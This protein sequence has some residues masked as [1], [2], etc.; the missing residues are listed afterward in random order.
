MTVYALYS[1]I[2]K[3]GKGVLAKE[4]QD[5]SCPAEIIS[6]AEPLKRMIYE[7]LRATGLDERMIP[8]MLH[9]ALKEVPL[10]LH[11]SAI[12][13]RHLMQTLGTEWGRNL[14]S[15]NLWTDLAYERIRRNEAAGINSIIDDM[16]FENE[17]DMLRQE[18]NATFI[19]IK[20]PQ[21]EN[22]RM[23]EDKH[24]SNMRLN[25]RPFEHVWCNKAKTATDAARKARAFA[26]GVKH[27]E[28]TVRPTPEQD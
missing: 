8:P 27:H 26:K 4:L 20:R 22:L 10:Q 13:P 14:V 16:R 28:E 18:F 23:D 25:F 6:F 19:F 9:G 12:T 24:A 17:Y 5:L 15:P 3:C 11:S 21:Y 2:P 1:S 7:L